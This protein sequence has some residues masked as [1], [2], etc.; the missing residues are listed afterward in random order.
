MKFSLLFFLATVCVFFFLCSAQPDK[1][2]EMT[3]KDVT[4]ISIDII[5]RENAP[6]CTQTDLYLKLAETFGTEDELKYTEEFR[7]MYSELD[8]EE[9][10]ELKD[11]LNKVLEIVLSEIGEIPEECEGGTQAW[12]DYLT[13]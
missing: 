10:K 8:E 2:R 3:K 6:P 13:D 9:Q 11:C 1:C 7:K 12:V 4:P 5:G